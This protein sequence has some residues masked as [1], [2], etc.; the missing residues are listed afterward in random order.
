MAPEEPDKNI[1]HEIKRKNALKYIALA[2]IILFIILLLILIFGNN[3]ELAKD[4]KNNNPSANNNQLT[5][6][7]ALTEEKYDYEQ[8]KRDIATGKLSEVPEG[9]NK[10]K[11][12]VIKEYLYGCYITEDKNKK[13]GCYE[14]YYLNA[15][16][17][18]KKQKNDCELMQGE[19][20]NQCLDNFYFEIASQKQSYFCNA[21]TNPDL[22]EE[23]SKIG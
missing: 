8:I 7:N 19:G 6:N 18:L 20:K 4:K 21:I 11:S 22:K 13:L 2:I 17:E 16:P 1:G 23:C 3:K 15:Y 5:E 12:L 9:I 14:G 10:S